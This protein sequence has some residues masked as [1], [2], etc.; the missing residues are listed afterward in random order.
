MNTRAF[1]YLSIIFEPEVN[2][3][4][5]P[6][7]NTTGSPS[8]M[9]TGLFWVSKGVLVTARQ[10][11]WLSVCGSRFKDSKAHCLACREIFWRDLVG[12]KTLL[13]VCL[14]V[15]PPNANQVCL[16]FLMMNI[17]VS[18]STWRGHRMWFRWEVFGFLWF[19]PWRDTL[20]KKDVRWRDGTWE[21]RDQRVSRADSFL[22][23]WEPSVWC[24]VTQT[25]S[26]YSCSSACQCESS[27]TSW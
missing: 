14:V 5:K 9:F 25:P 6:N 4:E 3:H 12:R 13:C 17:C 2:R 19:L 15:T 7:F 8:S 24:W 18:T 10:T 26:P 23:W 21:N 20:E 22:R 16:N 11:W 27:L 1:C